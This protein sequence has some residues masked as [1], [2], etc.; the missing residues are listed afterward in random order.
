MGKLR[1]KSRRK[2]GNGKHDM[3]E[4]TPASRKKLKAIA[5]QVQE[6]QLEL[7]R[8]PLEMALEIGKHFLDAQELFSQS[9]V[10]KWGVWG[11]YQK[12]FFPNFTPRTIQR[13]MK[14]SKNVNLKKFPALAFIGLTNLYRLIDLADEANLIDYLKEKKIDV[15][16]GLCDSKNVSELI[17]TVKTLMQSF[18]KKNHTPA[19]TAKKTIGKSDLEKFLDE[20][21]KA[22][23]LDSPPDLG[24]LLT[25]QVK[26][27]MHSLGF[28]IR[29]IPPERTTPQHRHKPGELKA[30]GLATN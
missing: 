4:L 19:G 26:M 18:Q 22:L 13:Y 5:R 23:N 17:G 3:K 21:R 16:R 11:K 2:K 14:L 6:K 9:G 24:R 25:V 29:R 12:E 7:V 20:L 8:T 15:P 30:R 10:K 27:Q 1:G 28:S